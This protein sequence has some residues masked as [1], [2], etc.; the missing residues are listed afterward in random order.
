ME[1]LY[2]NILEHSGVEGE[3]L[4]CVDRMDLSSTRHTGTEEAHS[5]IV[6]EI[7]SI[8]LEL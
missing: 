3:N 6:I 8:L 4:T 5:E 7:L 1:L 2:K